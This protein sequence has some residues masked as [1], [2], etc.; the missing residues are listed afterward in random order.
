MGSDS[1]A[2][3]EVC[4]RPSGPRG[5]GPVA[6]RSVPCQSPPSTPQAQPPG[7]PDPSGRLELAS[8][9]A[10][11][12][13]QVGRCVERVRDNGAACERER[14]SEL[15]VDLGEQYRLGRRWGAVELGQRRQ[16]PPI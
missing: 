13:G 14:S 4:A 15:S 8:S 6:V 10:Q 9:C 1:W 7:T 2:M 16:R 3:H 5:I 11:E 12:V